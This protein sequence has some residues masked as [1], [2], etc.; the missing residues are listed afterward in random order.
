M[1]YLKIKDS[2]EKVRVGKIVCVGRNYAAHAEELGNEIPKFPLIFLKPASAMIPSGEKIVY[3]DYSNEMHHEIELVLLIGSGVKDAD[4]KEAKE[5]IAGYGVGLDMTLR[6]I[7]TTLKEKGHPWTIAKCFDT[8]G[9][10]SEFVLKK[11]YNLTGT[12]KITLYVND[13]LRQDSNLSLMLFNSVEIVKYISSKMRLERGD[14]IFTGTPKGVGKVNK[15]DK[16]VG[17]IGN[18]PVL[19]TEVK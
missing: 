9:V 16:L 4:D 3:P 10:L 15:G 18:L 12:E 14:L 11:N 17:K 19:E 2:E 5:A 13:E 6:D 1:K 7:Q 8:A